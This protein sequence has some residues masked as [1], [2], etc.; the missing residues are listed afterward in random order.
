MKLLC[1]VML[2][3]LL[4]NPFPLYHLNISQTLLLCLCNNLFYFI[5]FNFRKSSSSYN[6]SGLNS[7]YE[8]AQFITR[9]PQ[10]VLT[11]KKGNCCHFQLFFHFF[12]L[13]QLLTLRLCCSMFSAV[14]SQRLG[15]VIRLHD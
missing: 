10:I 13:S 11:N 5:I 4:N 9:L 12:C 15:R 6:S 3:A 14:H 1:Y 7:H 8:G 2:R